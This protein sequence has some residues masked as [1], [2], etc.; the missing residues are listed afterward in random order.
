MD[1]KLASFAA[2]D[3]GAGPLWPAVFHPRVPNRTAAHVAAAYS[4]FFRP[5]VSP[6]ADDAMHAMLHDLGNRGVAAEDVCGHWLV[7]AVVGEPVGPV[8]HLYRWL[9]DAQERVAAAATAAARGMYVVSARR[10]SDAP[11][12]I[13][14]EAG[15]ASDRD[16]GQAETWVRYW[17]VGHELIRPG[18]FG[19]PKPRTRA[20][21]PFFH[22][23][24]P[25]AAARHIADE[26]T[27]VVWSGP[28][29]APGVPEVIVAMSK[30]LRR[31]GL[32]PL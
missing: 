20:D 21:V 24:L 11:G 22:P 18:P 7:E 31:R 4:E 3:P 14:F 13:A 29:Y 28:T 8:L 23:G 19:R 9:W 30:D 26:Y 16:A 27:R 2:D 12:G 5:G 32:D 6:D 15:V 10:C 1:N 25:D 17:M